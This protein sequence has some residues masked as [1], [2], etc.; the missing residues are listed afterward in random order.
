M[1]T[2]LLATPH[3]AGLV[4]YFMAK[5]GVRGPAQSL[6]KL[7]QWASSRLISGVPSGTANKLAYNGNGL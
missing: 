2:C 4:A 3:V 6:S 5:D 7:Q 1:L